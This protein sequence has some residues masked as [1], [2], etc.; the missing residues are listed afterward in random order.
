[1]AEALHEGTGWLAVRTGDNINLLEGVAHGKRGRN[2]FRLDAPA[3]TNGRAGRAQRD[4]TR[5]KEQIDATPN[6]GRT[7]T[8]D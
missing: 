4:A 7:A 1:V 6:E 5:A 3:T 2:S 8:Q